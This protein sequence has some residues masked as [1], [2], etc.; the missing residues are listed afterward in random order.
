VFEACNDSTELLICFFLTLTTTTDLN[1]ELRLK[2]YVG[3]TASQKVEQIN[4][5]AHFPCFIGYVMQ[6]IAELE[7]NIR[8]M[9]PEGSLAE[10]LTLN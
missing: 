8:I 6:L 9:A 3:R 7:R 2:C 1:Q 5:L 10:A 4:Y